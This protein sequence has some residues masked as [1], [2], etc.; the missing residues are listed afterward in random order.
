MQSPIDV[1]TTSAKKISVN[2]KA[3]LKLKSYSDR[4]GYC[5]VLNRGKDGEC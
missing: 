5:L 4:V 2:W 1:N 3:H